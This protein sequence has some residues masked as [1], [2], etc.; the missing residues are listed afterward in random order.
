[1][2]PRR[3][4]SLWAVL[5]LVGGAQCASEVD[6]ES[7]GGTPTP[8][9]MGT[10]GPSVTPPA[11][12]PSTPPPPGTPVDPPGM[13]PQPPGG[14]PTPPPTPQ[15]PPTP[16]PPPMPPT[17]PGMTP[18]PPGTPAGPPG[19]FARNTRITLVEG[20]QGVFTKIGENG[21]AVAMGMRNAPII[22]GRPLF[23][24]IHVGTEMGFTARQLRGVLSLDYGAAGK[25]EVE[26]TKMIGGAS[27]AAML[28]ST[29]NFRVP[30][31]NIKPNTKLSAF[32]YETGAAAGAEPT[33][34]PRFP[35]TGSVDL[36]VKAGRMEMTIVFVPDNGLMDTPERRKKLE[37]DV[38][39]LY[40]VQK[41]NFRFHAPVPIM[42]GFTS[43]KGFAIL[44]NL[45]EEENAKPWEYYHYLT[46]ATGAGFAGV[47]SRAGAGVGDASRRTSI[48]ITGGGM[49]AA[50]DGNTNTVAHET[51]HASGS[52]HMPGCGAAGPDMNYPYRMPAGDMGVN[53]YSLSF[54]AFKSRMMFRE[55]MSYC[56]PR[57]LSDYVYT[58][59]EQRVRIVTGFENQGGMGQM[60]A[61]RSLLGYQSPGEKTDWGIVAGT[62]VDNTAVMTPTQYATLRLVDGR[63]VQAPVAV[64]LLTDDATREF[65][66][67][68]DGTDFSEGEVLHAE[69]TIDG[70]TTMLPVSSMFRR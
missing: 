53:G 62:L 50:I 66:I 32:V 61:T 31:D 38:Y 42:G 69:V 64:N 39:D 26:E 49:R 15:P 56:R 33:N 44:R 10:P 58:R 18:P 8:P 57:W 21:E 47:S 37:Q 63:I 28:N 7:T 24:R 12:P 46:A 4:L 35:A 25:F 22:E 52:S 43:A 5:V 40:P 34:P 1:M 13:T 9:G 2:K 19:P 20:A 48:T 54:S 65:A 27:N 6:P 68:L 29:F 3:H 45:R 59:F 67:N 41:L 17:P 16:T 30:A 23:V 70:E 36:G 51:G 11:M 55:L 60:M 14:A